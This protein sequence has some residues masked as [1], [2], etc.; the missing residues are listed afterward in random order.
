MLVF[1]NNVLTEPSQTLKAI[2]HAYKIIL[3][4]SAIKVAR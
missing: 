2:K 1:P 3:R 4:D